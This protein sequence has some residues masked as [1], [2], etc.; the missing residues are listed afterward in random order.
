MQSVPITTNDG[1][2]NIAHGKVYSV[3]R[4]SVICGRSV[5]FSDSRTKRHGIAEKLLKVG[6]CCLVMG[7][8]RPRLQIQ[9][10]PS[11]K[12]SFTS[13]LDVDFYI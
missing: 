13:G 1:S 6:K 7:H 12:Y 5:V 4:L 11:I 2:S 10:T 8:E 3:Q 9:H